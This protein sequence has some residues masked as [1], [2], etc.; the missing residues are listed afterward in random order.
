MKYSRFSAR[1]GSVIIGRSLPRLIL[2][3]NEEPDE[4]Y[5]AMLVTGPLYLRGEIATLN[6]LKR[7]LPRGRGR[8]DRPNLHPVCGAPGDSCSNQQPEDG[9]LP[10]SRFHALLVRLSRCALTGNGL[11]R[12][13]DP[14]PVHAIHSG[15]CTERMGLLLIDHWPGEEAAEE[16]GPRL[17]IILQHLMCA[18]GKY[19]RRNLRIVYDAIGTLADAVGGELNQPK[20]LE[21]LMP[22]LIAKWQQLS[23]SDKDLFPLLECFTSIAQGLNKSLIENSA[24]TLGR[25]AWVCPELVSPHME[26]FMQPW[27]IALSMIRDDIEKEDAF[28]GLCAM[29]RANPSGALNSLVFMCKAIASWHEIRSEDLHNEVCQILHGYKQDVE[30]CCSLDFGHVFQHIRC[31]ITA[32]LPVV[33]ENRTLFGTKSCSLQALRMGTVL[34]ELSS[35]FLPSAE[36]RRSHLLE[37]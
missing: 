35:S 26:H 24:I 32:L 4:D 5:E 1:I 7:I 29:V 14:V 16:L 8:P 34:V 13:F 27:C 9:S 3:T 31:F 23:N 22:P 25:L 15:E 17:D 11:R 28:R 20:Y 30:P 2:N 10:R 36:Y 21:I 37:V 6:N 33:S 18:F 19:Q 12:P